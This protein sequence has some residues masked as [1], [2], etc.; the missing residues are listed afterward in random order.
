M[1]MPCECLNRIRE[2]LSA[3]L[4]T[5]TVELELSQFITPANGEVSLGLPPLHY[6]YLDGRKRRRSHVKFLFCPF[7][8]VRL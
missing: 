7:C 2:Q 3:T 8:G 1:S 4:A 5:P 6:R